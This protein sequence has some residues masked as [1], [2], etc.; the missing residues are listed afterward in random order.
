M[1]I[2]TFRGGQDFLGPL[3]GHER[4][5]VA[6][7]GPKKSTLLQR[8]SCMCLMS[9]QRWSCMYQYLPDVPAEVELYVPDVPAE[10]ELYVPVPT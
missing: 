8:C 10:V 6:I 9:Q 7:L 4:Q 1:K 5:R 3:N 2:E